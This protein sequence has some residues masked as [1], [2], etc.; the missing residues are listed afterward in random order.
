MAL[1]LH[2]IVL[3][4]VQQLQ[5]MFNRSRMNAASPPGAM[6]LIDDVDCSPLTP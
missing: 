5:I 3:E 1:H 2:H 6:I 4:Q